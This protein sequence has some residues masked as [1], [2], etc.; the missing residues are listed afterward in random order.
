MLFSSLAYISTLKLEAISSSKCRFTFTG[1]YGDM[2]QKVELSPISKF[3]WICLIVI[4]LLNLFGQTGEPSDRA[5][6]LE[7]LNMWC[8]VSWVPRS[9]FLLRIVENAQRYYA[10]TTYSWHH[11]WNPALWKWCKSIVEEFV[12]TSFTIC[13]FL[14]SWIFINLLVW[15]LF[16]LENCNK[17]ILRYRKK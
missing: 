10:I 17:Y 15:T 11:V 4:E 12:E 7:R 6:I 5:E 13:F 9:G 3:R 14:L 1:L 8:S 2:S 16:H